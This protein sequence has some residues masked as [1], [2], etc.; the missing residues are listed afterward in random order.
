LTIAAVAGGAALASDRGPQP[1]QPRPGWIDSMTSVEGAEKFN[2]RAKA[3]NDGLDQL[4]TQEGRRVADVHAV[5][6]THC[7]GMTG[8]KF[9]G[10]NRAIAPILADGI[11]SQYVR[12]LGDFVKTGKTN[13]FAKCSALHGAIK[14]TRKI[15]SDPVWWYVGEEAAR[16][17]RHMLRMANTPFMI[18]RVYISS[19]E[20]L[21]EAE[22]IRNPLYK[23]HKLYCPFK[24]K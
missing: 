4:L 11:C 18:R 7:K 9:S 13:N 1:P 17:E 16:L 5:L 22:V 21:E 2:R 15:K 24:E 3:I 8:E 20:T 19:E 12:D 10:G 14:H 23:G 6:K